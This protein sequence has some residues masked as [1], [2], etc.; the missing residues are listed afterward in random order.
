M[1]KHNIENVET[2]LKNMTNDGKTGRN[3]ANK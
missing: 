1:A 2:N 3:S